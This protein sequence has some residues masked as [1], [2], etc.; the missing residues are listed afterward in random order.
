MLYTTGSNP[1]T[2]IKPGFICIYVV[3]RYGRHG[4][5]GTAP[6][7]DRKLPFLRDYKRQGSFVD[8]PQL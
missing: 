5:A 1:R 8:L 3:S 6:S 7:R 2:G 4:R